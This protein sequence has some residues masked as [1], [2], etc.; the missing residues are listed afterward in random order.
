MK[1]T[2]H[3]GAVPLAIAALLVLLALPAFG[4]QHEEEESGGVTATT[5]AE[6]AT[7][8]EPAVPAPEE[9]PPE[10]TPDWTYRYL[11]PTGLAL[12]VIVILVTSIQ[13]FTNVVRK[14]YRIVEK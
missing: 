3:I 4:A 14:R 6:S 5:E 9:A 11:I 8:L 2:G 1:R 10:V 13:Y 12:A 7:G